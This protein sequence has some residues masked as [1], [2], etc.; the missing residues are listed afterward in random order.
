MASEYTTD[1][2]VLSLPGTEC[3]WTLRCNGRRCGPWT[4]P[5]AA[6]TAAAHHITG[7]RDWDRSLLA[8]PDD[9]L[10]LRPIGETFD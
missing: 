9:L 1:G 6:V 3:Q 2:G 8:V 5:D 10:N 4:S 7:L